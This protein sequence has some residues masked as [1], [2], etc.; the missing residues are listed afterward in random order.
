[1]MN[2]IA[3]IVLG[4]LIAQAVILIALALWSEWRYPSR[5]TRRTIS[6]PFF[7]ELN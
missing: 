2:A 7:I 5:M 3:H 6:S 4:Y 1:M